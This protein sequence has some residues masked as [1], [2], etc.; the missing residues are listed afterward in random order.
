ME[1]INKMERKF[2][3][4]VIR[5][6]TFYLIAGYILGYLLDLFMPEAIQ[7]LY[8]EPGLILQGQI[9][10]LFTWIIIPSG[11]LD[12]FTVF[13]LSFYYYIGSALEHTWG[14]FRYNLYMFSGILM[15]I[16]GAFALY[17]YWGGHGMSVGVLFTTYYL[18]LSVFFV[19]AILYPDTPF[20][21]YMIIPIKAKWL[22][23]LDAFYL[24]SAMVRGSFFTRYVII[25]SLIPFVVYAL[26]VSKK[27]AKRTKRRTDFQR[28]MK[29]AMPDEPKAPKKMTPN[30]IITR[31]KCAVCGA[32]EVSHPDYE[33]RFCSRCAG[34]YEYCQ[35]HI[36][37]HKHVE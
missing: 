36:F 12:I 18:F 33:F 20:M 13:V 32:T 34:N 4:Y 31:H 15:N 25:I 14:A 26:A 19:F 3:K 8:L 6:L 17:F 16:I 11:G 22:A 24:L 29:K 2:R 1:F 27:I 23:L 35:E 28:K 37:S 10:R 21:F 30:S 7:L 5:N 9:W